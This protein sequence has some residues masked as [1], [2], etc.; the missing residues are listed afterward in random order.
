[1]G[2]LQTNPPTAS[3]RTQSSPPPLPVACGRPGASGSASPL[4][5]AVVQQ[6][7][8]PQSSRGIND[9]R[10]ASI[11]NL[12]PHPQQGSIYE[13][14]SPSELRGL[15]DNL[16]RQGQRV[17]VDVLPGINKSGLPGGTIIDGHNRVAAAKLLGWTEIIVRIR[18]DLQGATLDAIEAAYLE[19]NFHR[20]QLHPLDKAAVALR[21]F[22]IERNKPRETNAETS[23]EGDARDRVGKAVGISGRHLQRLCQVLSTPRPVQRA[24]RDGHISIIAGEKV[25][26]LSPEKQKELAAEIAALTD[27]RQAKTVVTRYVRTPTMRCRNTSE[28]FTAF[29]TALEKGVKNFAGR[30]SGVPAALI[31]KHFATLRRC[32]KLLD[33]LTAQP[34]TV[35]RP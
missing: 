5:N 27:P 22:E 7:I 21:L 16:S 1:M 28:A 31:K 3:P 14:S 32:Q 29:A 35:S 11:Q 33:H 23:D 8:T 13:R 19:A 12:K 15:A 25:S 24:V 26:R 6:A 4:N 30:E 9:I 2:Q 17:P 18:F 20:R 10:N 34:D